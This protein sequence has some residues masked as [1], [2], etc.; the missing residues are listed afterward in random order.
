MI[1]PNASRRMAGQ[2]GHATADEVTSGSGT[3]TF[4]RWTLASPR[5]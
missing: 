4:L 1:D 2:S 3:G 5:P